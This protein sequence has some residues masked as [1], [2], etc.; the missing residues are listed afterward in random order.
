MAF[1][2][3]QLALHDAAADPWKLIEL[4]SVESGEVNACCILNDAQRSES[5]ADNARC[6]R[7]PA[8]S[9]NSEDSQ[10]L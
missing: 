3:Q 2:P 6:C 4:S 9:S 8:D 5:I 10:L 7:S 1:H